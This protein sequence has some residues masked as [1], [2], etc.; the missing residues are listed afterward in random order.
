LAV[1]D[2]EGAELEAFEAGLLDE[3]APDALAP[4]GLAEAGEEGTAAGE[5]ATVTEVWTPAVEPT[6]EV[7]PAAVVLAA[8][9]PLID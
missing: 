3:A 6:A 4:A 1:V 8:D 5:L 9:A 2:G 7:A